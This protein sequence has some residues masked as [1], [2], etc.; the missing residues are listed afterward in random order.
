MVHEW[1]NF[2]SDE[3]YDLFN[4]LIVNYFSQK[5]NQIN[6][7]DGYVYITND[8]LSLGYM[9]LMNL[10]QICNQNH[11]DDWSEIISSH[12]NL[13]INS[14]KE[15]NEILSNI[16]NFEVIKNYIGI[17]LHSIEYINA[18]GQENTIFKKITDDIIALL[19][20]DLPSSIKNIKP[21]EANMWKIESEELFNLGINNIKTKYHY[22]KLEEVINDIRI[23][24]IQSEDLF[25]TNV[26]FNIESD[27]DLIGKY[28]SLVGVPHRHAALIYPID[29]LE[30]VKAINLLIPLIVGMEKEGPGSISNNLLWYYENTFINLPFEY[31]DKKLDFFPP[32]KFVDVLNILS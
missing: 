17:R 4:Q 7:S 19:I 26:L 13:L 27:D 32:N 5:D 10:A 11:P 23:I 16:N 22:E 28:G 18:I 6:F 21:E 25:C 30:V 8:T 12:F 14:K 24:L 29:D 9:G 2:F 20:F 3:R 15:E 1:A 31:N